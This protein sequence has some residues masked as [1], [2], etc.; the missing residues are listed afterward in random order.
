MDLATGI[1]L[2]MRMLIRHKV[3]SAISMLG[4][5]TGVG[6]FICSVAIVVGFGFAGAVG[7]IF[8]LYPARRVYLLDSI[9]ALRRY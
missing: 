3:R 7:I 8:G 5:S 6:A 9:E 4:I 2:V 1:R